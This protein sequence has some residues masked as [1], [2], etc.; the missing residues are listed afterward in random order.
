MFFD[1]LSNERIISTMLAGKL[2]L[3]GQPGVRLREN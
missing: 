3:I 2:A 1:G